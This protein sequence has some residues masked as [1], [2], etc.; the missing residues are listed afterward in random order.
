MRST[1]R[2]ETPDE[3]LGT[4]Q[5]TP[6]TG[7]LPTILL[8]LPAQVHGGL[9]KALLEQRQEQD[10]APVVAL[11]RNTQQGPQQHLDASRLAAL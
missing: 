1:R 11:R 4:T 7:L 6:Q 2:I 5:T 9:A 10:A 8:Q 3:L